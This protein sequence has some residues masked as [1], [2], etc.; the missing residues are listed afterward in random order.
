MP[1]TGRE[2][3][4]FTLHEAAELEHCLM[5][6]YLYAAWSLKDR[7]DP[8]MGPTPRRRLRGQMQ[9]GDE[10]GRVGLARAGQL[11]RGA[12]IGRGA[13]HG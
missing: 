13:H 8:G 4:L 12:V 7:D 6:T 5:C 10:A 9:G 11:E 2:Q 1:Q 3:L